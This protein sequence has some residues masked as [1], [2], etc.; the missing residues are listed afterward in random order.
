MDQLLQCYDAL[1]CRYGTL[2]NEMQTLQDQ[3]HVTQKLS[4]HVQELH[5]TRERLLE[6]ANYDALTKLPNRTLLADRL[7]IACSYAQR[8]NTCVAV[9]MIDLDGFKQVNDTYG[10]N[11]GD[12]VLIEAAQRMKRISRK[13]DTVARLGGD[14]FVLILTK[15]SQCEES[16]MMLYRVVNLLSRPY[17]IGEHRIESISAS[18]GVTFYPKDPVAPD[19]LLR[20][21]DE[22]MYKSKKSGKNRFTFFD[23]DTDNKIRANNQTISRITASLQKGDFTLY[24]QPK[25][26]ALSGEI[27][28]VE[29]LARWRHPL[30]GIVSPSEFLPLIESDETLN[31]AFDTWVL[32]EAC[33]QIIAWQKE[34]LFLKICIN[35][36]VRLFRRQDFVPWLTRLVAPLGEGKEIFPFLEFE[37][38][39]NAA[40]ENLPLSKKI[41]HACQELGISFALDD[42][43]TGYS[44]MMHL[45]ELPIDTIKIDKHFV[46]GMLEESA[47]MVIVQAMIAMGNAF[48]IHV[49]AEGVEHIEQFITLLDLGC[50]D[51]QGFI[52]AK[53]MPKEEL[54]EFIRHFTPDPRWQIVA[55]S[56]PSKI[57]FELLLAATNHN[58]WLER[59]LESLSSDTSR[60]LHVNLPSQE[61]RMSQ[62]LEE[63]RTGELGRFET[64]AALEALH[65]ELHQR[66]ATLQDQAASTRKPLNQ[67]ERLLILE[68]NA[69]LDHLLRQMRQEVEA[70]KKKIILSIKLWKKGDTMA[71]STIA[72][73]KSYEVGI[74]D[75]DE[76]HRILVSTLKEADEK[77]SGD[78][79]QAM[80]ERITKDLL[81][82]ALYH[83]ETEEEKMQQYDYAKTHPREYET[84]MKQHRD[85]S[86]K[87][88]QIRDDIKMNKPIN[89]DDLITFLTQWLINRINKTDKK[90]GLFLQQQAQ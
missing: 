64:F 67:Q 74:E 29:A 68:T 38:L 2:S 76:Q 66:I 43:G 56:L 61:C 23:V 21:A 1:Q 89:K 7:E 81:S 65:Q 37:I 86:A 25:V 63:Q 15:L 3:L 58:H 55:H 73:D 40:L 72:W 90:L 53:P 22:A 33:R 20:H 41:I 49:T 46:L 84:H 14:E 78:A 11:V 82:Y 18:I 13:H 50:D 59:S 17:L 36:S 45:K 5:D 39:E 79:S 28:E 69:R 85:F 32:T 54:P 60:E 8:D 30:L 44:S 31:A 10:H 24:Y 16:A 57:D 71:S 19:Q 4:T 77:L 12:A 6:L 83:F 34:G 70:V 51:I 52:V 47:N 87:V 42:F 48:D 9:C 35:L 88:V 62:W 26:N 75:I 27:L 80:L